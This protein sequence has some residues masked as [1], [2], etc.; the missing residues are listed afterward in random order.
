MSGHLELI[1]SDLS[2]NRLSKESAGLQ[3]GYSYEFQ[4]KPSNPLPGTV[5]DIHQRLLMVLSNIGYCK[6]E[7]ASE[8]Y[9]KYQHIW[10]TGR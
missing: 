10:F 2:Q 9:N 3:N 4:E 6:D 1:G 7:L 5:T 8:L